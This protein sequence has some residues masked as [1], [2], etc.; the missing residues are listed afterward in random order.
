ME[1]RQQGVVAR[2]QTNNALTAPDSGRQ[3]RE[4][5]ESERRLARVRAIQSRLNES[6]H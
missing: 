4:H 3:C 1:D 2:S 6:Q 5:T